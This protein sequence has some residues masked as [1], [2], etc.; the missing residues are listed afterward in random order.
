[1]SK[2]ERKALEYLRKAWEKYPEPLRTVHSAFGL[3][4]Y[5]GRTIEFWSK[6]LKKLEDKGLVKKVV[7]GKG[8][9]MLTEKSRKLRGR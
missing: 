8:V 5:Y 3:M 1:M 4:G 7:K 6:I 2:S 9:Y